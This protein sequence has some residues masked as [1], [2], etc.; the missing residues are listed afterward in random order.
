LQESGIFEE[1][2]YTSQGTQTG[3]VDLET[4]V[5]EIKMPFKAGFVGDLSAEI[6]RLN[7]FRER[8]EE[9]GHSC[10]SKRLLR[11]P[12]DLPSHRKELDYCRERLQLLEDKVSEGH[13]GSLC[14]G[15]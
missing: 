2:D 11:V 9:G 4:F 1:A 12:D 3:D 15:K 14:Q 5:G 7:Q 8:V 6:Q 10:G 13:T